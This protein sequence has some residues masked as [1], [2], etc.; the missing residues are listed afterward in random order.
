MCG[1]TV[2][3]RASGVTEHD[4]AAVERSNA[5][6]IYRGPNEQGIWAD[7][8]VAMGHVRL[9]IIGVDNGKQPIFSQDRSIIL[10]CN[11]EIYNHHALREELEA[12]GSVFSTDSD[13]EVI[14]HAYQQFGE[15]FISRLDGMFAFVMYDQARRRVIAARDRAGKKPLYYYVSDEMVVLSSELSAIRDNF[16]DAPS[17]N[18][19]VIRQ[20]QNN[21]YSITDSD[22]YIT[23]VHK[24]PDGCF[25]RFDLG[26]DV[27]LG[28][29]YQRRIRPVFT[30]S[31]EDAVGR[32][33]ELLF[34]AVDKRLESEVPLALLLSAGIDSSAIACI[35]DRLGHKVKTFSA[36]Y[37]RSSVND[38]SF[39]AQILAQSLG[40]PFERVIIE[41]DHFTEAVEEILPILDEPNADPS[42]FS[43]W[44]L[45]KAV[46][47][48]GY[49]VL[50]SGIGG[51][52]VFFGYAPQNNIDPALVQNTRKTKIRRLMRGLFGP[53]VRSPREAMELI[54]YLLLQAMHARRIHKKIYS[55]EVEDFRRKS[56]ALEL[57]V[58]DM[59]DPNLAHDIDKVYSYLHRVFLPNNGFFLADKLAMA[60]SLEI[61]CPF[62]DRD[63]LEFVDSL[64]LEFRY[65]RKEP[66]GLLKDA[67]R[68]IVPDHVLDRQKSGFT[69]PSRS[70]LAAVAAYRPRI[71]RERPTSL[72]QVVTDY[73]W[74]ATNRRGADA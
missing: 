14:V 24:T 72:A 6:M 32:T 49:T 56:D 20:V 51:D 43:Q 67:L 8:S 40:L 58:E 16:V 1:F 37:A 29:W 41:E 74:A 48:S 65:P 28:R 57:R 69:P 18:V 2:C 46:R 7:D 50:L 70:V 31:Y 27:E 17:V 60:Q 5:R 36:G 15:D 54:S 13:C 3:I 9:S 68:G 55:N 61:R 42:M 63:L 25:L 22:T 47:A 23:G 39:E 64:P 10:V 19:E 26:G 4:L 59:R 45:Y 21:R 73:F 30:G 71:F 35:A 66:K 33:R 34:N 12:L 11:G 38:E 52:E 53:Q 44:E 62:A